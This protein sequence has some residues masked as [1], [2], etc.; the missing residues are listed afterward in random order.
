MLARAIDSDTKE[1]ELVAER[2]TATSQVSGVVPPLGP[3]R[4]V[5]GMI[6][7]KIEGVG[8]HRETVAIAGRS[9]AR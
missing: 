8:C 9:G 3:K 1:R 6:P 7:R 4:G 2:A 5:R